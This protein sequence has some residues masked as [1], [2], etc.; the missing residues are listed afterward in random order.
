MSTRT[1]ILAAA[2]LM[3]FMLNACNTPNPQPAGLT[4]IPTLAPPEHV[5]LVPAIQEVAATANLPMFVGAE[6]AVGAPIYL[7][8]CSPCHGAQGQGVDAPPLRDSQYIQTA[9]DQVI[10]ATV[11][12][13]RSGTEM[14]AWLKAYGGPLVDEEISSVVDYL[15]ELQGLPP[16]PT[17]TPMPEEPTETPLPPGAPTPEPARPSEPGGPGPA[18]SMIGDIARGRS[19]FGTYCA[20]CHGPEGVQGVPNPGSDDGSVP[21]LNPIDPTIANRDPRIF[22]VNVDLFIEHGSLPEG[23]GPMIIMPFFGDGKM[24]TA[25]QIADLI[26]YVM[27]LNGVEQTQ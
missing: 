17:S 10:F 25:Q 19:G 13:G 5:T 26:A 2:L 14:P 4:P 8:N 24:L 22:A 27:D 21:T 11:A 12:E 20:A 3:M 15:H 9:G 6:A 7:E 18:A 23:P 16:L 1:Q